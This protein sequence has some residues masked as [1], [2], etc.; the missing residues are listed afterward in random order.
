MQVYPFILLCTLWK[1]QTYLYQPLYP[2]RSATIHFSVCYVALEKCN[3]AHLS[4]LCTSWEMQVYSSS[5]VLLEKYSCTHFSPL[6]T[7][8]KVQLYPFQCPMYLLRRAS[9]LISISWEVKSTPLSF[10]C[11]PWKVCVPLQIPMYPLRCVH[12]NPQSTCTIG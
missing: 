9:V 3:C 12:I 6:C 11:A 4:P 10:P 7:S 5:Y 8:W 1:V 2:L